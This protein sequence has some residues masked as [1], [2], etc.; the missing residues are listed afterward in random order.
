VEDW[1]AGRIDFNVG[2]KRL[3]YASQLITELGSVI[4]FSAQR[5]IDYRLLGFLFYKLIVIALDAADYVDS[6]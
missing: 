5:G 1:I 4:A 2:F 3:A 6:L